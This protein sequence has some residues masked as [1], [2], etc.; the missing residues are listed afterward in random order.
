MNE[1]TKVSRKEVLYLK[2]L[3]NE[4]GFS[5]Y[6]HAQDMLQYDYMREGDERGLKLSASMFQPQKQGHLSDDP[7]KN[8][9]YLFIAHTALLSRSADSKGICCEGHL[10]GAAHQYRAAG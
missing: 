1:Q 5:H 6:S 3:N 2:Y 4:R 7:V 9:R 10:Q 8:L